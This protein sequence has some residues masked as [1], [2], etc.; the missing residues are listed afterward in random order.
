MAN[1]EEVLEIVEA[2]ELGYQAGRMNLSPDRNHYTNKSNK[3][4]AWLLGHNNGIQNVIVE[5]E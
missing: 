5:L 1:V 4:Y 2:Y 3:F